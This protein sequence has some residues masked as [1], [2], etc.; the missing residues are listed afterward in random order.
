MS[1]SGKIDKELY[2]HMFLSK[3]LSAEERHAFLKWLDES[4]ENKI[5]FDQL[6]SIWDAS[7]NIP[8]EHH[9]D[10]Q[11]ALD[12]HK[13]RL[14]TEKLKS[15]TIFRLP[16]ASFYITAAATITVFLAV[17]YFFNISDKPETIEA[18]AQAEQHILKDNSE[19]WLNAG[20]VLK[21]YDLS[22]NTRK[23]SLKG[24]AFFDVQKSKYQ[25]FVIESEFFNIE[26]TG[27]SFSV[28]TI[29]GQVFV[30]SGSVKV[31]N[32][33]DTI[34]VS[35]GEGVHISA[36]KLTKLDSVPDYQESL[37][38]VNPDLSFDNTSFQKVV[39]DIEIKYD[40]RIDFSGQS[41]L[42]DCYFTSGS[43]KNNTLDEVFQV[44]SLTYDMKIEQT[45]S[46]SY[47]LTKISCK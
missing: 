13:A 4:N 35:R 44:L 9:F 28:N 31:Y 14:Q 8:T 42:T 33:T 47:V 1:E 40:V 6:S 27:T 37:K 34:S 18:I 11:S 10:Y 3:T 19:V 26:V 20:S 25:S 32:S 17:I 29:K 12:I 38:W 2:I 39:R 30:S 15:P 45:N 24:N 7:E 46:K 16:R 36:G 21:I 23:V 22:E 41:E 43:M 5:L